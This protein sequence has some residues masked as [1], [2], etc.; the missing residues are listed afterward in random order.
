MAMHPA[1]ALS[2]A[3]CPKRWSCPLAASVGPESW[4]PIC[5]IPIKN[6]N[7]PS[8]RPQT[9]NSQKTL[10]KALG[11]LHVSG[12][13]EEALRRLSGDSQELFEDSQ[14]TLRTLRGDLRKLSASTLRKCSGNFQGALRRLSVSFQEPLRK[15]S[16]SFQ[17]ALRKL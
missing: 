11:R 9:E 5:K 10:R 17:E 12:N 6:M 13:S 1:W 8:A 3:Q 15:L 7:D 2:T 14:E 16:G 4:V